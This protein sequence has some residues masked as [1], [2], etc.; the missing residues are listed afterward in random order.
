LELNNC[1]KFKIISEFLKEERRVSDGVER[2]TAQNCLCDCCNKKQGLKTRRNYKYFSEN[3][4]RAL[5][6]NYSGD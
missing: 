6:Y 4:G 5:A 2:V 3:T 1:I